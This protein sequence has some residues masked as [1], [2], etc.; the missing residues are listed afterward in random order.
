MELNALSVGA[1]Q[2]HDI[3]GDKNR[4]SLQDP[5]NGCYLFCNE[6]ENGLSMDVSKDIPGIVADF[7]YQKLFALDPQ[8]YNLIK[9]MENAENG[10][11][12]PECTPGSRQGERSKRFLSFGIKR[13]VVPE[14]EI[15]EYMTYNLASV[16]YL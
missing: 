9:M 15:R 6:N 8:C 12:T 10:D 11:G 1:W 7:L 3:T 5:F 2:P 4:L 13:L 16:I 14:E